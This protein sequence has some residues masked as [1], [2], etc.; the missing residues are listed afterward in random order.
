LGALKKRERIKERGQLSQHREVFKY[1]KFSPSS[2]KFK[3]GIN[4]FKEQ[5]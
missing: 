2:S 5:K 4:L 3:R 1:P